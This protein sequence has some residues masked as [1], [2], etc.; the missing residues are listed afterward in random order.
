MQSK[1]PS[2]THIGVLRYAAV[3]IG[4]VVLLAG[5]GSGGGN[6]DTTAPDAP[7]GITGTSG[8]TEVALDWDA[9]S[10]SDLEEY[11]IYRS[12]SGT[13]TDVSGRDP[14]SSTSSTSFTD[15][16]ATNGTTYD[17]IVTA[18]DN[19]GNESAPSSSLKKTP[20]PGPPSRP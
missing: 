4:V 13:I 12:T 18:V 10:A 5:C 6:S 20:F 15:T 11:N 17:Y 8:D 16:G 9:V 19:A 7:S 14:V 1:R 3:V 2:G